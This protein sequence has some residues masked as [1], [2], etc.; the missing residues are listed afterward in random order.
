MKKLLVL[1]L[2]SVLTLTTAFAEGIGLS[3]MN[4]QELIDLRVAVDQELTE[5]LGGPVKMMYSGNYIAGEDIEEGAYIFFYIEDSYEMGG[6]FIYK[7]E[8]EADLHN[9]NFCENYMCMKDQPLYIRVRNGQVINIE[10]GSVI[11][12][13]AD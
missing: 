1:I 7:F 12:V 2:I 11:I 8:T 10:G 13:K 5:K 9:S 4:Q 3:S 6:F